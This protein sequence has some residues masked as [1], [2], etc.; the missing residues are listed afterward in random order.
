[1]TDRDECVRGS[2]LTCATHDAFG[3]LHQP[4]CEIVLERED[5]PRAEFEPTVER[6]YRG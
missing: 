4:V 1:M 6:D 2:D 5:D 3:S